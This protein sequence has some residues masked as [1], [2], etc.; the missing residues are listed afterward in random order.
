LR[1]QPSSIGQS[2]TR[3]VE[4]SGIE[5]TGDGVLALVSISAALRPFDQSRTRAI[6]PE[7]PLP[8]PVRL[9]GFGVFGPGNAA[10]STSAPST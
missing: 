10:E 9:A 6:T 2:A 7:K 4:P 3:P 1:A 5:L 8:T